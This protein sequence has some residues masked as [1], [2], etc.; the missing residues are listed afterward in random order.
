VETG[1]KY[2]GYIA[3]QKRDVEKSRKLAALKI[4]E[5]LDFDAIDGL[6]REMR[7]KLSRV[8]PRT[9]DQASR[10]SGVTPAAIMI[11]RIYIEMHNRSGSRKR[12]EFGDCQRHNP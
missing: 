2:A 4:P 12:P 9:L 5:W 11:L 7:Q 1:V 6:S 8:R 10:I 3:Q